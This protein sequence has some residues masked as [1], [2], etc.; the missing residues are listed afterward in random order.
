VFNPHYLLRF[1]RFHF[2]FF[3]YFQIFNLLWFITK[4]QLKLILLACVHTDLFN[5]FLSL[6]NAWEEEDEVILITCRLENLDMDIL[7]GIV[8]DELKS[9][10]TEL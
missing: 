9:L 1:G 2:F 6:A 10:S 4:L 8:K 3:L 7:N 5:D